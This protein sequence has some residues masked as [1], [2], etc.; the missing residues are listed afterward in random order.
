[1]V[2]LR[3]LDHVIQQREVLQN[4]RALGRMGL[5]DGVFLVRQPGVLVQNVVRN[6]DLADI[7]QACS[8]FDLLTGLLIHA[9]CLGNLSGILGDALAVAAGS[10]ILG[11]HRA[12]DSDHGLPAHLDLPVRFFQFPLNPLLPPVDQQPGYPADRQHRNQQHVNHEPRTVLQLPL[13]D[14]GIAALRQNILLA[15]VEHTQPEG[16][17]S[18]RQVGVGNG[19]QLRLGQDDPVRIKPFQLVPDIGLLN[20]I[21]DDFREQ[22][23]LAAAPGDP[24]GRVPLHPVHLP[25]QPGARY[26][27]PVGLLAGFHLVRIDHENAR[28]TGQ[29]KLP[30]LPVEPGPGIGGQRTVQA[31]AGIQQ[32]V[33]QIALPAQQLR[34]VHHI[35]ARAGHDIERI[36][37]LNPD[38]IVIEIRE[39]AQ[40]ADRFVLLHV[41]KPVAGHHKNAAALGVR[42]GSE[43]HLGAQSVLPCQH[44]GYLFVFQHGDAVSVRAGQQPSILHLRQRQD[45]GA[46]LAL[47]VLNRP[48]DLMIPD[49]D[50]IRIPRRH[51]RSVRKLTHDPGAVAESAV[52]GVIHVLRSVRFHL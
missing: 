15:V 21:V 11:V 47:R 7:M 29:E 18:R 19:A 25:V 46:D 16:I 22:L 36:R 32:L 12:G 39:I 26:A 5:H 10:G 1:M 20:R 3:A 8:P 35:D 13:L 23:Q 50:E 40:R 33:S 45:H 38:V 49:E 52:L 42:N 43:N 34:P 31:H 44:P 48:L 27:H 37:S 2:E 30:R 17:L 51:D 4:L 6:T 24:D 9:A 28:I 41:A 14:D